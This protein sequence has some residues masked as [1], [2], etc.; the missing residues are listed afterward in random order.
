MGNNAGSTMVEVLVGFTI[1]MILMAGITGLINVSSNMLFNTHDMLEA[2]RNFM[3]E[4]YKT[5]YG[6][7]TKDTIASGTVELTAADSSGEKK[8]D[9]V[10]ISLNHA[11]MQKI[12]DAD[13]GL[14]IYQVDY[15]D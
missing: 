4:Y 11:V 3:Q 1:L 13:N 5:N 8:A 6:G 15:Q 14:T 7:L 9:G 12:S 2:Q 10:S